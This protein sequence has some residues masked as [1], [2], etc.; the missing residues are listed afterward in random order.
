MD[1]LF[2]SYIDFPKEEIH[3]NE[4]RLKITGKNNN[5]WYIN[6]KMLIIE[7]NYKPKKFIREI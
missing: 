5:H 7:P 4:Y 6:N 2:G 1:Y 3:N